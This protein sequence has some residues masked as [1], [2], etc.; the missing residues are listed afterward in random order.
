MSTLR[1]F[2][3]DDSTRETVQW[4]PLCDRG[5]GD[6][7]ACPACEHATVTRRVDPL[8]IVPPGFVAAYGGRSIADALDK[9]EDASPRT[10]TDEMKRCRECGTVRVRRKAGRDASEREPGQY[11]C[12][13]CD[14]HQ[15]ALL[16]PRSAFEPADPV[17]PRCGSFR[18]DTGFSGEI[19]CL[20]CRTLVDAAIDAAAYRP[21]E[22]AA[23]DEVGPDGD[24]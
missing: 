9:A 13:E 2:G 15:D 14:T 10:P 17:C 22:Q 16:P 18:L 6:A 21:D 3:L 24:D 7:D 1:D 19:E 4:C 12:A 23:L 11:L 20:D 8:G 5:A